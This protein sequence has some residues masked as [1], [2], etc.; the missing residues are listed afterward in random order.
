MA[1]AI[2]RL[3]F[4]HAQAPVTVSRHDGHVAPQEKSTDGAGGSP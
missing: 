2:R 3:P 4:T 1:S